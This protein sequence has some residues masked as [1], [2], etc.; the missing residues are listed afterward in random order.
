LTPFK[1]LCYMMTQTMAPQIFV[2]KSLYIQNTIML[3]V[4]GVVVFFLVYS[5]AKKKPKHLI[6]SFLWIIIVVWFFNS[7]FF[8]FSAVSVSPE[9]IRLNYGILSLRNDLL[10]IDSPWKVETHLSG[11]RKMKKLYLIRIAARESMKVRRNNGLDLLEKIG[12][13]IEDMKAQKRTK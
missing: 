12:G 8:G 1:S 13:A 5:L 6:A 3:F 7:P 2:I 10:P 9:G 11:I 4:L